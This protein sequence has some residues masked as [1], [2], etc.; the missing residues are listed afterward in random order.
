MTQL[1]IMYLDLTGSHSTGTQYVLR[2]STDLELAEQV[3]TN[4]DMN[5]T[6]QDSVNASFDTLLACY[7]NG[8]F[9]G[10]MLVDSPVAGYL[11]VHPAVDRVN[12]KETV[13]I[14]A[15]LAALWVLA[16]AKIPIGIVPDNLKEV[17]IWMTHIL[18][19]PTSKRM[20]SVR[21]IQGNEVTSSVY[22]LPDGWAPRY[23][24]N[25]VFNWI[26]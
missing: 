26:T 6:F 11:S 8:V 25:V 21:E 12:Y 3:R 19:W 22:I 2:P 23:V 13:H 9:V 20:T 24:N 7:Y 15:E 1:S 18:G 10:A 17:K 16:Q 5:R 14:F 4:P